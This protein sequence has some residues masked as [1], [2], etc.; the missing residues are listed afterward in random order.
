[1][2]NFK[3]TSSTLCAIVILVSFFMTWAGSGYQSANGW[4][5]WQM[6]VSPGMGAGFISGLT[7]TYLLLVIL[8]PV[9]AAI[10]LWQK[11]TSTPNE[12]LNVWVKRSFFIPAAISVSGFVIGFF[13]LRSAYSS[14]MEQFGDLGDVG[15]MMQDMMPKFETPGLTDIL[16]IGAYLTLAASIYLAIIGFG[17]AA[18]K[19]L[20]ENNT[21]TPS[22]KE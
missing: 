4:D 19:L 14:A 9:S 16:G 17:R 13:K 12:K 20:W 18:D 15:S 8:I 22:T 10:L 5:M 1:M 21:S 6:G 3:L 7:R 2:N 11:S